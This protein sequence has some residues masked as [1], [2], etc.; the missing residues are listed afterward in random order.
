MHLFD[1]LI[2]RTPAA[3][4]VPGLALS[5]H[6]VGD[7][8]WEFSLREGV[9]WHDGVPFTADDVAFT[10]GR[11][12]AVPN[13]PGGF[14][15]ML[16]AVQQVEVLDALHLRVHTNGPAPN[17]PRDLVLLHIV[18]RHAGADATTA[19][20]NSGRAAIGTGP[21]RLERAVPGDRIEL[22]RNDAWWGA[23]PAWAKVTLR[24]LPN[25]SAR[26]AALLAGDV[27]VIDQPA[28]A[29]LERRHR[30]FNGAEQRRR[31]DV[32]RRQRR[33][34]QQTERVQRRRLAAALLRRGERHT[35]RVSEHA[36]AVSM[37]DPRCEGIGRTSGQKHMPREES[38]DRIKQIGAAHLTRP[39]FRP[40]KAKGAPLAGRDRFGNAARACH[41]GIKGCDAHTERF[42]FGNAA[43]IGM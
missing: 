35:R 4:P 34:N 2:D 32:R 22:T 36:E 30:L 25:A 19:D 41:F 21:Y 3:E 43:L 39:W 29:D 40:L 16:R 27:D 37:N 26:S 1:R 18:S 14:A 13:S 9:H 42:G 8:A 6:A 33:A 15:G 12:R 20:Y 23:Q 17:L 28:I 10:F 38:R 5:W 31:R 7:D 11:A 24:V